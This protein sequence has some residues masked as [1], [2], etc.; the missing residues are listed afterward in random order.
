MGLEFSPKLTQNHFV[1]NIRIM[2]NL[3]PSSK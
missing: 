3:F 2:T 1:Y